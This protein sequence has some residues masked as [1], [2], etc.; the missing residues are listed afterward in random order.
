MGKSTLT[1]TAFFSIQFFFSFSSPLKWGVSKKGQLCQKMVCG[2]SV[3]CERCIEIAGFV[4]W[5]GR[6]EGF[7]P[8]PPNY[9][10]DTVYS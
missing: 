10:Q 7:P 3:V 1:L 8:P 6:W 5:S 4:G 9:P 2:V